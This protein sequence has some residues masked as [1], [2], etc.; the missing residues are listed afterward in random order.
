MR[1]DLAF[2]L[3]DSVEDGASEI[4]WLIEKEKYSQRGKVNYHSKEGAAEL[5]DSNSPPRL[6]LEFVQ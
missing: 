3:L 6:V 5:G 4:Q 2:D 1:G